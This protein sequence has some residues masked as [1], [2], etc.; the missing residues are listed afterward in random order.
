[1]NADK[2]N[3]CSLFSIGVDR[4]LSAASCVSAFF[5][6]LL[7]HGQSRWPDTRGEE[8]LRFELRVGQY[9]E[10]EADIQIEST[11]E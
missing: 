5:I 11:R 9:T 6:S 10:F 1:M 8:I 2:T 7:V 4:C 3:S